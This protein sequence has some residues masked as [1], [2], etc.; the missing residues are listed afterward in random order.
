MT[1]PRISRDAE[2]DLFALH[3]FYADKSVKYV[4]KVVEAIMKRAR[5]HARFPSIGTARDAWR[6]GLRSFSVAG[7]VVM[8][9]PADDT[10]ELLHVFDGRRDIDSIM[11]LEYPE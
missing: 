11:K 6:P 9:R 1:E 4:R 10:I 5:V 7:F 2:D 8:Y 3:E